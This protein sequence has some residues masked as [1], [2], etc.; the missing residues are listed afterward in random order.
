[1][2]LPAD[3]VL[4][5]IVIHHT[6]EL[7]VAGNGTGGESIYGEKFADENFQVGSCIDPCFYAKNRHNRADTI[8]SSYPC[9]DSSWPLLFKHTYMLIITCRSAD[10]CV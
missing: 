8:M 7:S 9:R 10:I 2:L 1:M 4:K 5:P 3:V 6:C